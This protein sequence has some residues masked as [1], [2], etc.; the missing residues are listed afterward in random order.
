MT[1][2]HRECSGR[3][4]RKQVLHGRS[5]AGR[6]LVLLGSL[7]CLLELSTD[8]HRHCSL[9]NRSFDLQMSRTYTGTG[10]LTSRRFTFTTQAG[11]T[12]AIPESNEPIESTPSG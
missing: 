8:T 5:E 7:S 3:C 2:S 12:G 10:Y 6:N 9:Y 1:G 11:V 4:L